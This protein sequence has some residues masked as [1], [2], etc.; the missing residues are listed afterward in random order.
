VDCSA[1][2][3]HTVTVGVKSHFSL[4]TPILSVFFGGS[5]DL[6]LATTSTAQIETLP[7]PGV[8]LPWATPS[9]SPSPSASPSGSPQ[10]SNAACQLPSAGF[11]FTT[12]PANGRAPLVLSVVD[13]ST[14]TTCGIDSWEWNWGDGSSYFGQAP[15]GH[16]YGSAGSYSVTLTVTNVAGRNTT[17][18]VIIRVK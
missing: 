6:L 14:F 18:A 9:P 13:T 2:L 12:S 16:N 4:L 7:T 15:G 3:G 5:R 17:G 8:L 10:P 1:G 11:T